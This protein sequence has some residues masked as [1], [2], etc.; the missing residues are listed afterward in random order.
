[1]NEGEDGGIR[2]HIS[3][4]MKATMLGCRCQRISIKIESV[5]I[6]PVCW[7]AVFCEHHILHCWIVAWSVALAGCRRIG[8][9]S[10]NTMQL[11][12]TKMLSLVFK[13]QLTIFINPALGNCPRFHSKS[14]RRPPLYLPISPTAIEVGTTFLQKRAR[15]LAH[16]STYLYLSHPSIKP[17]D[18]TA[19]MLF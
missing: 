19:S 2:N 7:T 4:L 14:L 6:K 1:M 12:M 5:K 17:G 13:L 9:G 8:S 15:L 10:H 11:V 3:L 16:S 18:P